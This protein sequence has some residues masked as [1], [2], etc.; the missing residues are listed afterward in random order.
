ERK[1]WMG[2]RRV[3]A[4]SARNRTAFPGQ[5]CPL[6]AAPCW[7]SRQDRCRPCSVSRCLK[8]RERIARSAAPAPPGLRSSPVREH[9]LPVLPSRQ[10]DEWRET[11]IAVTFLTR[12]GPGPGPDLE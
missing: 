5:G 12:Q 4:A 2:T 9:N 8:G 6:A 11:G 3:L 10:A 1:K 7:C